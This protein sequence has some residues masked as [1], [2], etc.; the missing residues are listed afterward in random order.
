M[1][2]RGQKSV[3]FAAKFFH[4]RM[5]RLLKWTAWVVAAPFLLLSLTIL[6]LY[7]PPVQDYAVRR[8]AA[9]ASEQTGM[10]I[11]MERLRLTPL[12]DVAL[13]GLTVTDSVGDTLVAARR[14]TVD[15][16]LRQ[17]CQKRVKVEGIALADVQ[18]DTKE[19]ITSV[20]VQGRL[21]QLHLLDDIDLARQHLAVEDLSAQ[22]VD[23]AVTLVDTTVVDTTESEPL[24]WTLAV[25]H[26]TI[27]DARVRLVN[28]TTQLLDLD[29]LSLQADSIFLDL[30]QQHL[31]VPQALLVT[32]SSS[33]QAWTEMD[34]SAF[35][36]GSD[37][38]MDVGVRTTFSKAD[39]LRVAGN[40]LPDGFARAYPD[41]PLHVGL[42]ASGNIEHLTLTRAEATL[43]GSIYLDAQGD[44]AHLLDSTALQGQVAFNLQ[45]KNINWVRALA[46]GALDG[47]ALP[48]MQLAGTA[49]ADGPQYGVD[50]TL[51]EA[52]GLA[53]L[54][55]NIDTR[56]AMT[57]DATLDVSRLQ[58]RHFL[59]SLA[60]G[61]LT[62]KAT[63]QGSGTDFLN[64]S[65]RLDA[66]IVIQQ[67]TYDTYDLNGTTLEAHLAHGRGHAR[68]QADNAA[69]RMQADVDALLSDVRAAARGRGQRSCDLTFGIDLS[70]ADLHALGLVDHPL[71]TAMCLHIDGTTDLQRHHQLSGSINDIVLMPYDSI[72]RPEDVALEALLAPD[73]VY[74]AV[75]S[76]DLSVRLRGHTG[77]D[78]LL[79][80]LDHFMEELNR[81]LKARRIDEEA[82]AHRLPQVDL[83]ISS[84]EHNPLHDILASM[85]YAFSDLRFGINLDPKIGMNGGGHIYSLNAGAILLDTIRAHIYQD[86]TSVRMD[87]RV[88]N[89]RRN[90]QVTF[91]ATFNAQ[92]TRDGIASAKV[93]YFDDR[94]RKGVDLGLLA[95]I[96]EDTL[97]V[98]F[99]PLDPIIAYRTFH[100]NPTN[101]VR[102]T[103]R[104]HVD[105]DIDLLADDGTGLKIYSS[106]NDEALQDL[107]VSVNRLNLGELSSVL[108]YL[109]K[110]GGFLH[111]DA[112]LIQ[113]EEAL[114]V[115]TDMTVD[116][117]RYEQAEL[118]QVGLQA[119]YLPNADG[120]HF[121]DGSL[122]HTG[123]P[124]ASFSGTYTPASKGAADQI[125]VDATLDRLP[126]TLAN[127]FIPD[128]VAR[129]E[130]VAIG[131]IHVGG[132]TAQ[133][134][135]N[136]DVATVGLRILSD[137]YSLNLRVADDTISVRGSQLSLDRITL[138]S[139]GKNPFTMDGI[140]D[141]SDL[142]RILLDVAMTA[143]DFELINAKKSAR[144]VAYGKVF[145]DFNAK[146]QGT[147]DN[148]RVLGRLKVL[149]KTDVTYVLTD[150]PL[151]A[152]DQLADL[153]EFVDFSDTLYVEKVEERKP[154][155][156]NVAMSIEIA[157]AAQVH[158]LL[159]PDGSSY[160]DLE[161]G[162]DL[163]MTYSP[164][165]D[166]QLNGRYTINSGTLKYTMM[167][168]PLKEFTIKSGSYAEFRGPL[169]NPALDL[170]AT[171]RVRT[172]VTEGNQPRS[173]NFNVGM[174]ITQTL[175]NLGLEFT[176]EAPE[177]MTIQND[178]STMSAEQRGRLAVTML[179]TGMYINDAG[180]ATSG[181]V[182]G[183]NALNAFLQSQISNITGKALKSIDLSMG[184]E[185][186][187]SA[188]GG[189]TTDYTFRF[190]KRFWGNRISV[191]VGGKVSTGENAVNTGESIIDN[192]SIEY[193][194]DEGATRYVNVF[195]D[196]NYESLLD[197]E[198]TEMGVGLVLRRKTM[199]LG[200]LF[201]F[202]QPTPSPSP[203]EGSNPRE[204]KS[205]K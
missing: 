127:G 14:A 124:V 23:V 6:L 148:L 169:S 180:A 141:F 11:A 159:S 168:I 131:D 93:A 177:D 17:I 76:G 188:T 176:L 154:Q 25:A 22:G 113:T 104:N 146:A 98:H 140:I 162:G 195:Y 1:I 26:A 88:R 149:G 101:F 12:L 95:T 156:L 31:R 90:P 100:I 108:P 58:L 192:V 122:L 78:R 199:R 147:L 64:P 60:I 36:P 137:P 37:G 28:D 183:Q 114:S 178:L 68:L 135:V 40:Y 164:E 66:S 72:F 161:G 63:V 136:G 121:V 13:D 129:L 174:N 85:G 110:L 160:V 150:S 181:G 115:S 171:E 205:E 32:P 103:K 102:L 97:Q 9:Y 203:R 184:V 105:A 56:A 173:V 125:D 116:G 81:Q 45:T 155:H 75:S 47:V 126:L 35:T 44:V 175:Q 41:A 2:R 99:D 18:L 139:T 119:V 69:L 128:G 153:V 48:P 106:P 143:Q 189:A 50:A 55:G 138:Y 84:G 204:V 52:G 79:G 172:T 80:Q 82:L 62:A 74:A 152:D 201:L 112:H 179:A 54:K 144:S 15:L 43:P 61:P 51:T 89:N 3:T 70:R 187:T 8:A 59:P 30:G 33:I 185:Q 157:D 19:M 29:S 190:A 34:F 145:V 158:C 123:L 16:S 109:P 49:T 193:R 24:A 86:S 5:K 77:Y 83:R 87:A 194:L 53:Y 117:L 46:G 132:T 20:V 167:V 67:L 39:L 65:S 118:G 170:T 42:T 96:V 202:K 10:H 151:T 111:G 120:S 7:L 165:K 198:V 163:M 182:T 94:G 191:I 92:L 133:P 27:S 73:T 57:Y 134:L 91:D 130:G 186:G 197:G 200:E 38:R 142:D 107:S 21:R 4:S 196:K 71:K 166:L